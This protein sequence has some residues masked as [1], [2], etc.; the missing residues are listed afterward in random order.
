MISRLSTA[1][2]T[3]PSSP[4]AAKCKAARDIDDQAPK[5]WSDMVAAADVRRHYEGLSPGDQEIIGAWG[6]R[7]SELI[8]ATA[9][10][11]MS[12]RTPL[13][14]RVSLGPSDYHSYSSPG[15]TIT[16]PP[17]PPAKPTYNGVYKA[18]PSWDDLIAT[19][20]SPTIAPAPAALPPLPDTVI[21]GGDILPA[22]IGSPLDL[23]GLKC[24][25]PLNN[26]THTPLSMSM[27]MRGS[28]LDDSMYFS[29][30]DNEEGGGDGGDVLVGVGI[31][32]TPV[33]AA[34]NARRV[35]LEVPDRPPSKR[36]AKL[37]CDTPRPSKLLKLGRTGEAANALQSLD[38]N[39]S[40]SLTITEKDRTPTPSRGESSAWLEFT[41]TETGDDDTKTKVGSSDFAAARQKPTLGD[42]GHQEVVRVYKRMEVSVVSR[43]W[44]ESKFRADQIAGGRIPTT[45]FGLFWR[46]RQHRGHWSFAVGDLPDGETARVGKDVIDYLQE[47]E[48]E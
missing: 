12:F 46:G 11:L 2:K 9:V 41:A 48:L 20:A 25:P 7:R 39:A 10:N 24:I 4:T 42:G 6:S 8:E 18:L 19:I 40:V 21:S 29:L 34:A 26:T 33:G 31:T 30:S 35:T 37:H 1:K 36:P 47:K 28:L 38:P 14:P 5:Q 23:G 45:P 22:S 17:T 32:D 44:A 13:H 16:T 27:S 3:V 43:S 15:S